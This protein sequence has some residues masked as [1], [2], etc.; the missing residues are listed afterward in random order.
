VLFLT[1]AG[2]VA[3][4]GS[5]AQ[6]QCGFGAEV[7]LEESPTI[8]DYADWANTTFVSVAAGSDHSLAVDT[9]GR[10]WCWGANGNKQCGGS[11]KNARIYAPKVL[12]AQELDF[13]LAVDAVAA[14]EH[15]LVVMASGMVY[16]MGLNNLGVLGSGNDTIAMVQDATPV[17]NLANGVGPTIFSVVTSAEF[18][19]GTL[20]M[21]PSEC[22]FNCNGHGVC[23]K[24]KCKCSDVWEGPN[25]GV[26]ICPT[27]TPSGAD[28]CNRIGTCTPALVPY[29]EC[30]EGFQG[31]ACDE[32]DCSVRNLFDCN[33]ANLSALLGSDN[34]TRC[35]LDNSSTS[36]PLYL[37][38]TTN[39]TDTL[40]FGPRCDCP[41]GFAQPN[42]TECVQGAS[43]RQCDQIDCTHL[44][45]CNGR[46]SCRLNLFENEVKC[47]CKKSYAGD[48]CEEL[49]GDCF[50]TGEGECSG[51]GFCVETVVTDKDTGQEKVSFFC[52]CEP[53]WGGE[54]CADFKCPGSLGSE[55]SAN[56]RCVLGNQGLG[57]CACEN[58]W[59]GPDCSQAVCAGGELNDC[60]G[61]GEC[62]VVGGNPGC[63][64]FKGYSG[65][66]CGSDDDDSIGGLI[67]GFIVALVV[68]LACGV[69][70]MLYARWI[71]PR[72]NLVRYFDPTNATAN[73]SIF[74]GV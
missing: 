2:R 57:S 62:A 49:K 27:V 31:A 17:G 23:I 1:G 5:N 59:D 28:E 35:A 65:S 34:T 32:A 72:G 64:C 67:I 13:A 6:G 51:N 19:I 15:S 41:A 69:A 48:K 16:G 22:K 20:A 7:T 60:N 68:I 43:G 44:D 66:A 21:E 71:K 10:V 37:A 12:D 14:G 36:W 70:Y 54:D 61:N 39:V 33:Y 29:C 46:G 4:W 55:C 24:G 9:I 40:D 38:N 8:V 73:K 50:K 42:C 18:A 52:E 26:P 53:R 25:C 74:V 47:Q 45:D 56:G 58:N 3:C 11:S 30:P 63:L